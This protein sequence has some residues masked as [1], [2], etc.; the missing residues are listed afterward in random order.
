MSKSYDI[1]EIVEEMAQDLIPEYHPELASARIGY[2]YVSEASKSG[3]K[4]IMGK[5]RKLSG[6]IQHLLEK[7]FLIEVALDVWNTLSNDQ[8]TALIDHLLE[9]CTGEEDEKNGDMKWKTR[10]PDVSEFNSVLNRRGA[11]TEQLSGMV[12]VALQ[13]NVDAKATEV[14]SVLNRQEPNDLT[15]L[16][17]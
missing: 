8:R 15:Q 16:D 11:W 7:D 6:A 5:A 17:S 9:R 14:L 12:D 2:I 10:D 3:G 13:L 4:P 1:A